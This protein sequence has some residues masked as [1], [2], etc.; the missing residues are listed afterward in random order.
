MFF[1]HF[2]LIRFKLAGGNDVHNTIPRQVTNILFSL[3]QVML[4]SLLLGHVANTHSFI[5]NSLNVVITRFGRVVD[6]V[7]LQYAKLHTHVL[8]VVVV[9]TCLACLRALLTNVLYKLGVFTCFP[10]FIKWR[11]WRTSING[12]LGVLHKMGRSVKVFRSVRVMKEI[13]HLVRKQNFPKN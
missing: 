5:S 8:Q 1:Y 10:C 6:H 11:I 3:F 7:H 9:L 4:S 13:I 2:K 12:V